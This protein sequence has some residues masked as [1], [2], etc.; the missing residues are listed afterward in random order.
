MKCIFPE[1]ENHVLQGINSNTVF[2]VFQLNLGF[3]RSKIQP[4]QTISCHYPA[5]L[6][7]ECFRKSLSPQISSFVSHFKAHGEKK[8]V[9]MS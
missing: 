6:C 4:T 8:N 2:N 5:S 9:A 7:F 1:G 3:H